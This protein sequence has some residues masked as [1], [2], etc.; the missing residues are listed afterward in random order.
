LDRRD[1]VDVVAAQAHGVR[2]RTGLTKDQTDRAAW[3]V[4]DAVQAG[5]PRSVALFLAV[6]W[7]SK[8][9]LFIFR[10]PGAG[11]LLDRIYGVIAAN[12]RRLP[13]MTPWC[14]SHPDACTPDPPE[15]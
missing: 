11:W 1:R 7:Q 15:R 12:R 8:L 2:E 4:T 14:V 10:V 5:G 13:G 9:P 6:A 3:T